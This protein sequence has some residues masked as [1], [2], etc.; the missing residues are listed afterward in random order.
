M[1]LMQI[2][3]ITYLHLYSI[4]FRQ[5]FPAWKQHI[6]CKMAWQLLTALISQR[7][8]PRKPGLFT[9]MAILHL[10]ATTSSTTHIH[11]IHWNTSNPIFRRDNNDH[12]I[13]INGGNHPWE[14]DQVNIVCP[15]Y[16]PSS[17]PLSMER[18]IIY[19]VSKEEYDSCQITQPNPKIVALCNQP[20][21]RMYFTI[22]FRSFT[23][24]P[25]GLEFIPGHDYYFISTSSKND[26][27]RRMGGSC[28]SH[29][30]KV[31]F[32]VA[33]SEE[34]PEESNDID[35]ELRVNSARPLLHPS[36]SARRP[37]P[38]SQERDFR[39]SHSYSPTRG[40]HYYHRQEERRP[41]D[42]GVERRQVSSRQTS[43]TSASASSA[44]SLSLSLT[45]LSVLL[46]TCAGGR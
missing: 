3:C 27:H 7:L 9:L 39:R 45:F 1:N 2:R 21:E 10:V 26:L 11:N 23:P 41:K 40:T 6:I 42:Y 38:W 4:C 43:P 30:M 18:Y 34:E 12:V 16:K 46:L 44:S 35:S 5:A 13:D 25:G 28:S 37:F 24:T 14:Y 31:V 32:R 19:S 22:T 17:D 20:H 29:N 15:T 36:P 8:T 33:P